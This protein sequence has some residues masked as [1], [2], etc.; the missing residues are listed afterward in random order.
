MFALVAAGSAAAAQEQTARLVTMTGVGEVQGTPDRAW[1]TVGVEARGVKMAAARESAARTIAKVEAQLKALGIPAAALRTSSFDVN[2]DWQYGPGGQR[3]LRGY[4]VS[5]R[6][7]VKVDDISKVPA[8]LDGAIAAGANAIEGL[9]WDMQQRQALEREALKLAFEDARARAQVIAV[10]SGSKLGPVWGVQ[11]S[12]FGEV[13]PM[14]MMRVGDAGV[15][16]AANQSATPINPG[17]IDLRA[18]VTVSFL[19]QS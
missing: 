2:Q 3:T 15:A 16:G 1:V 17:E 7:E 18:T 6:M 4:V 10:A 13:R 12:R 8:V 11:E 9:R 5:N 14:P 19:I